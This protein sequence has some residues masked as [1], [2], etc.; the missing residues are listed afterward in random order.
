MNFRFLRRYLFLRFFLISQ[1]IFYCVFFFGSFVAYRIGFE[2][3]GFYVAVVD[4]L[5]N[6]DKLSFFSY[7]LFFFEIPLRFFI[8]KFILKKEEVLTPSPKTKNKFL[9]FLDG[10]YTFLLLFFAFFGYFIWMGNILFLP[11]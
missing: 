8:M 4:F 9:R 10:L 3:K 2:Q 6:I 7:L 1:L 11:S 5:Y